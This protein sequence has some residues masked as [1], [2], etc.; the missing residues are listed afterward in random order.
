MKILGLTGSIAM[1]KSTASLMLKDLGWPVHSADESVH[2]LYTRGGSA[3]APLALLVPQAVKEGSIQRP[4][5]SKAIENDLSLLAKIEKI[6]H[7]WVDDDRNAF[8]KRLR[9]Q[10]INRAAIDVPLLFE[11]GLERQCHWVFVVSA[12]KW[13]QQQRVL[14]RPD[15]T[16]EKWC[17]LRQRQMPDVEKR[18]RA[19][20]VIP[21]GANKA[22][23]RI[24]L[25][26]ALK[27]IQ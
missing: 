12:P 8:L 21:S 19:D 26:K 3:I 20:V 14:R 11:S 17:Y 4:L 23:M 1:G 16:R 15:M 9:R 25:V 22:H 27:R 10:G 24:A 7:R 5:L 6:V 2:K 18:R 13:I